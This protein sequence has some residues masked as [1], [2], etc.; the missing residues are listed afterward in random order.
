MVSDMVEQCQ[1]VKADS[2]AINNFMMGPSMALMGMMFGIVSVMA[3][4]TMGIC[5]LV[6]PV[7]LNR[8]GT[9]GSIRTI[10]KMTM[11]PVTYTAV[12][13]VQCP[14]FEYSPRVE[15]CWDHTG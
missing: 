7:D 10:Q 9:G 4:Y 5:S 14:Q 12:R 13:K 6:I 1:M 8:I 3:L 15:G 2:L 11:A